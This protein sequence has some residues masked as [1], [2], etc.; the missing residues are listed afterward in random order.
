VGDATSQD[1]SVV[2]RV[3]LFDPRHRLV[4]ASQRHC[5]ISSSGT[6]VRWS[7]DLPVC[8]SKYPAAG[9][10]QRLRR[11]TTQH[12]EIQIGA[13]LGKDLPRQRQRAPPLR[14]VHPHQLPSWEASVSCQAW[15]PT[16]AALM[17]KATLS[18][19]TGIACDPPPDIPHGRHSGHSMDTFSY[20]DVVTYTCEPG[21]SLAGD[22]SIF[23]TTADGEHGVWSGPPPRCGGRALP[24]RAPVPTSEAEGRT[25]HPRGWTAEQWLF[26]RQEGPGRMLGRDVFVP[27]P[28]LLQEPFLTHRG[29]QNGLGWKGPLKAIQS[30]SLQ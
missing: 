3:T 15:A 10:G 23:C 29:S 16:A 18:V 20:A 12:K 30:N 24:C 1:S 6:R 8:Q 25:G 27:A 13:L 9:A 19:P 14:R 17:L 26:P 4:G 7:D 22:P 11:N 28:S 2:T 5:V 21:H